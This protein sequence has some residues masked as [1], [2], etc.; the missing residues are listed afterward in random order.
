MCRLY[1]MFVLFVFPN[2]LFQT[3]IQSFYI[4]SSQNSIDSSFYGQFFLLWQ[5]FPFMVFPFMVYCNGQYLLHIF[6]H[7]FF[8]IA[9]V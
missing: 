6:R 3:L 4:T 2:W 8:C 9:T 1:N 5:G 7:Y